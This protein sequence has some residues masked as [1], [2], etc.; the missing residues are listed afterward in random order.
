MKVEGCDDEVGLGFSPRRH[1][2]K[3][4]S[5][6]AVAELGYPLL[7]PLMTLTFA[8][9]SR[10]PVAPCLAYLESFL[11]LLVEYVISTLAPALTR[12]LNL[13]LTF[14]S[15]TLCFLSS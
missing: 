4:T 1:I 12:G 7:S 3:K 15:G 11:L 13:P 8:R 2:P 5:L 14:I 10:R 9:L 6:P